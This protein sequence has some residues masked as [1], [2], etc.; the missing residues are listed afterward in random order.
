MRVAILTT[1]TP[2]HAYFVQRL[3][4]DFEIRVFVE[5]RSMEVAYP[6]LHPFEAERDEYEWDRWFSRRKTHIAEI[7]RTVQ[8][9]NVNEPEA[10]SKLAAFAPEAIVVFGTGRIR[11]PL[12]EL[13][14]GAIVNLHGGDSESYRGLDTHLWAIWHRDFDALVTTLHM[15]DQEFDNGAIVLQE[16]VSVLRGM[17]VHELRAANTAVCI[18]MTTRALK[19]FAANG[20]F[21]ARPQRRIGRYYSAMPAVLKEVSLHRFARYTESL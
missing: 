14:P 2:H 7:A 4:A 11:Q 9:Q 17:K 8:V 20:S 5:N 21:E 15:L 13:N 12:I 1:Q 3:T 16:R 18:A 6:I 19:A 10:I